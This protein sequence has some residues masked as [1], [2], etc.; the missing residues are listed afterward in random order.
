[1]G[2]TNLVQRMEYVKQFFLIL[3]IEGL[4]LPPY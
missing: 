3:V 4:I 2:W 1:M